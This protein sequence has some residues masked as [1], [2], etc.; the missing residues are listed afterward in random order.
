MT[1][2]N[3]MFASGL[4]LRRSSPRLRRWGVRVA[5]SHTVYPDAII[6]VWNGVLEHL[7]SGHAAFLGGEG[8]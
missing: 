7:V 8:W 3:R 1:G 4:S 2:F 5:L 6:T